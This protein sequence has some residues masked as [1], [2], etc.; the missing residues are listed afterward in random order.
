MDGNN[1][2]NCT[3]SVSSNMAIGHCI[4]REIFFQCPIPVSSPECKVLVAYGK[5]CPLFPFPPQGKA[6]PKTDV[7]KTVNSIESKLG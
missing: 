7:D 6:K 3:E 2:L 4:H 1:S 5:I